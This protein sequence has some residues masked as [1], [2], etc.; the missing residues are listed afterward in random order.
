MIAKL[1]RTL[2]KAKQEPNGELPHTMGA[3]IDKE[4][5]TTEYPLWNGQQPT[6]LGRVG[7]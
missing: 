4:L 1:E 3:T 2:S 5:A 6:P 7:A